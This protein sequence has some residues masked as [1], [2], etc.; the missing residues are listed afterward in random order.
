MQVSKSRHTSSSADGTA[1]ADELS[2]VNAFVTGLFTLGYVDVQLSFC[3]LVGLK[4]LSQGFLR[5]RSLLGL[6]A[7]VPADTRTQCLFLGAFF[8]LFVAVHS[9]FRETIRL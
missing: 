5:R 6:R 1:A 4:V 2:I 9:W 7:T 3:R 8:L